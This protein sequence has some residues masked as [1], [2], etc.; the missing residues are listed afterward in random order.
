MMKPE[1]LFNILSG[2]DWFGEYAVSTFLELN[3]TVGL[4][5]I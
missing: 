1:W 4:Q 5:I 3:N 2:V